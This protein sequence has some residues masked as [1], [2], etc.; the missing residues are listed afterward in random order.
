MG[1][2][3]GMHVGPWPC[4]LCCMQGQQVGQSGE[5][6][7]AQEVMQAPAEAQVHQRSSHAKWCQHVAKNVPRYGNMASVEWRLEPCVLLEWH[8]TIQGCVIGILAKG[9]SKGIACLS[10]IWS[11]GMVEE[12]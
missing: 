2:M 1:P 12:P 9:V 4:M 7:E 3:D 8:V 6:E 11:H 10:L 5:E